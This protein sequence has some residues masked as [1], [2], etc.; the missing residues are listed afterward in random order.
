MRL[1]PVFLIVLMAACAPPTA[2]EQPAEAGEHREYVPLPVLDIGLEQLHVARLVLDLDVNIARFIDPARSLPLDR[3]LL[4]KGGEEPAD[5]GSVITDCMVSCPP[6]QADCRRG[7]EITGGAGFVVGQGEGFVDVT[8]GSRCSVCG[9]AVI[10]EGSCD[11]LGPGE[12]PRGDPSQYDVDPAEGDTGVDGSGGSDG[13]SGGSGSS[14]GRSRGGASGS[15]AGSG[16]GSHGGVG[17]P[18]GWD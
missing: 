11:R 13:D 16:G 3:V 4:T 17:N 1:T 14:G 10:C 2:N 12:V 6:D 9:W 15:G 8:A 7:Y 18:G 5:L